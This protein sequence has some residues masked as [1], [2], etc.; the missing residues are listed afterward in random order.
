M[1]KGPVVA[2]DLLDFRSKNTPFEMPRSDLP[3]LFDFCLKLKKIKILFS[4]K[5]FLPILILQGQLIAYCS[6]L[7]PIK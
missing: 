7:V 2:F 6:T 5:Q 4:S 3:C 1:K